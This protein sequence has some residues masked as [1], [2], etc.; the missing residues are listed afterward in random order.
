MHAR[1]GLAGKGVGRSRARLR[2][3]AAAPL[4]ALGGLN[5]GQA[6]QS[7]VPPYPGGLVESAGH[8]VADS[9][10]IEVC[11]QSIAILER[12]PG[13]PVAVVA[14]RLHDR[15]SGKPRWRLTDRMPHPVLGSNEALVVGM[16]ES[17]GVASPSL[18]A[19]ATLDPEAE[20]S[21]R[22]SAAWRLEEDSG[23][24]VR[25]GAAGVRCMNEGFGL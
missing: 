9:A 11:A 6:A 24:F 21:S 25:V 14:L 17:D 1:P 15:V 22:V 12:E 20:W 16:C 23:R 7:L 5:V 19:V 13:R 3:L 2:W 10:G 8:C 18:M 4:L